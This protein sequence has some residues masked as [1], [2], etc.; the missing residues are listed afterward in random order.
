MSFRRDL[1]EPGGQVI[2]APCE[3]NET[4]KARLLMNADDREHHPDPGAGG[5]VDAIIPVIKQASKGALL[6]CMHGSNGYSTL[7]KGTRNKAPSTGFLKQ[8]L[9][10]SAKKSGCNLAT[11]EKILLDTVSLFQLVFRYSSNASVEY[12]AVFG[13]PRI[14][15]QALANPA[16]VP[17][18]GG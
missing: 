5:V 13:D 15:Q 3:K 18:L 8:W 6:L 4:G 16:I 9:R 14:T 11:R 17:G 10:T 12:L 1:E 2:F 7:V